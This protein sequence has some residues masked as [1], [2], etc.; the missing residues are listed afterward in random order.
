MTVSSEQRRQQSSGGGLNTPYSTPGVA[1]ALRRN[2]TE[3]RRHWSLVGGL[4]DSCFAPSAFGAFGR[5]GTGLC[6]D[7]G[8][9]RV[10]GAGVLSPLVWPCARLHLAYT[11]NPR[12][13]TK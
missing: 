4:K 13:D 6:L 12:R 1:G 2:R 11:P 9:H 7:G 8:A 5:Q 10:S 3:R